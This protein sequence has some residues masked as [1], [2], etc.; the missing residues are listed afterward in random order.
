MMISRGKIHEYLGMTLDFSETGEFKI[1]MIPNIEDMVKDFDKHNDTMKISSTPESYHLFK[2]REDSIILEET[3][4]KI[5]HNFFP[6]N[7]FPTR[8][9]D[10][11]YTPQ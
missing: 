4:A 10:H 11:T 5:Y 1:T 9:Q 6:G 2:T 8:E 3:Q 7:F